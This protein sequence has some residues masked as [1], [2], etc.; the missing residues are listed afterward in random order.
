MKLDM[1]LRIAYLTDKFQ[2]KYK[3]DK[4]EA[5]RL[6]TIQAKLEEK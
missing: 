1:E 2:K 6:A 4:V 3:L 5:E